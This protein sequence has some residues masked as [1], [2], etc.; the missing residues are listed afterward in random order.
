MSFGYFNS[1][2]VEKEFN[3][4]CIA[5]L[6]IIDIQFENFEFIFRDNIIEKVRLLFGEEAQSRPP[7]PLPKN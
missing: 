5:K 1:T 2:S 6:L 3:A 4:F 7:L